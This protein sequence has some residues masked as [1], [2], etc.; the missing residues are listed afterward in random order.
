[1]KFV[2]LVSGGKDSFYAALLAIRSGH[3]LVACVHL[4]APVQHG[5]PTENDDG[6][7]EDE[8]EEESYMYQTAA[9]EVVQTL[10]E[11][12]LEVPLILYPRKGKSVQ[13]G[14]VYDH[15]D[16]AAESEAPP[17][18]E[19]D[20]VEDLFAALQLAQQRFPEI[21][22][23]SSGAILSTYQRVRVEN[24]CCR[25]GL[26]SL[27]YMWRLLPQDELLP[28]MLDDGIVAILVKVACPPGLQPQKH[29]GQTLRSLWDSGHFMRL[30][31]RYQFH[32]CGEGGEYESLVLDSPLHKKKLVL[33]EVEVVEASNDGVGELRILKC[34][35][36]EK[37]DG[38]IPLLELAS[39]TKGVPKNGQIPATKPEPAVETRPA[40]TVSNLPH[41]YS[42]T[43]GLLHVSE[44]MAPVAA[45][46]SPSAYAASE[47]HL[48]VK[49]ALDVF[50]IL[51][52]TLKACG[53]IAQDVL[54]VHLYLS[55]MSHFAAI[56]QHYQTLFGSLLPPSRSCVAVGKGVLPGGRRVLLDFMIQLGSGQY[57]RSV[58]GSA[59][60][61]LPAQSQYAIAA[62]AT[63]TSKLRDVLHVQSISHWA[64][65]CVGP[66]SQVNTLRS[67]LHLLA[68]QI[69]LVPSTMTLQPTWRQQLEQCWK[70]VAAVMDALEGGSLLDICG[71]LIYVSSQIYL[72]PDFLDVAESISQDEVRTN[73]SISSG[74]IDN[75]IVETQELYGGYEDEGTWE[76]MKSNVE[77]AAVNRICPTLV[78]VIP[79]MPKGAAIEL[80]VIASTAQV[81]H[82]LETRLGMNTM[83]SAGACDFPT[84]GKSS[85]V[86]DTGYDF[87]TPQ[88]VSHDLQL[89]ARASVI[90]KGCAAVATV[91]SSHKDSSGQ[92][93]V[94]LSSLLHDMLSCAEQAISDARAGLL[95]RKTAVHVRLFY[96]AS[97]TAAKRTSFPQDDGI[98]L[99]YALST[100][101]ASM[102]GD[103]R[104]ATT[105][106]PVQA[107]ATVG[108]EQNVSGTQH[109][110]AMQIIL[111][112]PVHF[113]T[114]LWIHK[115][116]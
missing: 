43:G 113:E 116:R 35:T 108:W 109:E 112:D 77:G 90:G 45:S 24:V 83:A 73:G 106:V 22:A 17:P 67:C 7:E 95:F 12:C 86:W 40:S 105:T 110:L 107:I 49:E 75:A 20:E 4:A 18:P 81:A 39:K 72:E 92:G 56:N 76:E 25:L 97:N 82:S 54:F 115:D 89:D 36:E 3:E 31:Q 34:H 111:I 114:E 14:L 29:L 60:T 48:A 6:H 16:S 64:P 10:V 52:S 19:H 2:A 102:C 38:D 94:Q 101:V 44:I 32:V 66:Y 55:E 69:G 70:N 8:E 13:T 42:G 41:I 74:R 47:S 30:H 87:A 104:P 100:A 71:S 58:A 68:G 78:V 27:G 85:S 63:K 5:D 98:G 88:S 99:R 28:K 1:M 61:S 15:H 96:V 46:C 23:V 21:E 79:E 53:A 80:E 93:G 26:T 57:M 62:H 91:V 51:K 103:A 50:A 37:G 9:S 65:V 33:D 84:L 11:D 59:T